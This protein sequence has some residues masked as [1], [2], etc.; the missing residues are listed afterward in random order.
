MRRGL[1]VEKPPTP[2][3]APNPLNSTHALP[4]RNRPL[5]TQG[6]R[7]DRERLPPRGRRRVVEELL[8]PP[9]LRHGRQVH[10]GRAENPHGEF[11]P[12]GGQRVRPQS[13]RSRLPTRGGRGEARQT[14]PMVGW[15][16]R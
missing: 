7:E 16:Y 1:G 12:R 6:I 11:P 2:K 9:R 13:L 8:P 15:I 3:L 10:V 4:R 5:P 14:L